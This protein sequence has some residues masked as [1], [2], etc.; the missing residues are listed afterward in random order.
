MKVRFIL[1]CTL[2]LTLTAFLPASADQPP[3]NVI[4]MIGDGMGVAQLTL[5]RLAQE[6]PLIMDSMSCGGLAHTHSANAVV[7]DSAAGGTALATG[8][9]TNNGMISTLPD[10]TQVQTILEAAA[11]LGKSTGLVTTTT[12]THAT[13]ASFGSHVPSRASENDIAP[14]YLDKKIDVLLGGGRMHFLHKDSPDSKRQDDRDLIAEA[15]AAGYA[16]VDN[17][18]SL[19]KTIS[20]KILGLFQVGALT[21]TEPEPSLAELTEK[22]IRTLGKNTKGFFLMVEGGQIDWRCHDNDAEGTIKHTLDFDAAVGKAVEF[23]RRRGDTLVIVTADHETGGLTVIAP[24]KDSGL[25]YK[26]SWSTKGHSGSSV[27]ILAEG[28]CALGFSGVLDNTDIPK[29]IAELWG[30]GHFAKGK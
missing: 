14:Q 21:C 30:I 28:P 8:F 9:K 16:I 19:G 26:T 12:I 10:G 13:P 18:E 24:D 29:R 20:P 27:P 6:K 25:K 4:L 5:T 23:A 2:V 17:R 22:A 7:T 3:K 1:F 11:G 15:R